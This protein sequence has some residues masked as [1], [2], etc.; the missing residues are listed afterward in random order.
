MVINHLNK[1]TGNFS[2]FISIAN[3]VKDKEQGH[4]IQ[5]NLYLHQSNTNHKQEKHM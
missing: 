3:I 1:E 5:S 2:M 4:L